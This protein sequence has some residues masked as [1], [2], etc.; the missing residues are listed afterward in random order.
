LRRSCRWVDGFDERR[1]L[2]GGANALLFRRT[3]GPTGVQ[4]WRDI[5]SRRTPR[6]EGIHVARHGMCSRNEFLTDQTTGPEMP[7]VAI[8]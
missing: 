3:P 7:P 1:L 6:L 5:E 2:F 8:Y 4:R